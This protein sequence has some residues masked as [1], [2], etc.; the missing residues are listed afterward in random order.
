VISVF[1][2]VLEPILRG[3][4]GVI[5]AELEATVLGARILILGERPGLK[6]YQTMW[7]L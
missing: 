5:Y 2:G 1:V 7:I 3:Y 6:I 4:Q